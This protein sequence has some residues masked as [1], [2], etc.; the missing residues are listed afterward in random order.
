MTPF[1]RR[2]S[3]IQRGW[4]TLPQDWF[5]WMVL[6]PANSPTEIATGFPENPSNFLGRFWR[7][8]TGKSNWNQQTNQTYMF[9]FG[10]RQP[11]I[12]DWVSRPVFD[13]QPRNPLKNRS[14]CRFSTLPGNSATNLGRNQVHRQQTSWSRKCSSSF[15]WLAFWAQAQ[16]GKRDVQSICQTWGCGT[17]WLLIAFARPSP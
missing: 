12:I 2:P 14:S 10:W 7:K 8:P 3:N 13:M 4:P 15:R 9:G 5:F 6:A 1:L 16:V 17:T 11:T